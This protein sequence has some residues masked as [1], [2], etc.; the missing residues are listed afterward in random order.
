MTAYAAGEHV[1]TAS[2]MA[3]AVRAILAGLGL[4]ALLACGCSSGQLETDYGR[5]RQ[6]GESGSING[7]DVLADMFSE[8]GHKI[9]YRSR[10]ITA[11]MEAADTIVWFPNDPEP[12]PEEVCLWFDDWLAGRP[13][14]T[15]IYVGRQFSATSS[16]WDFWAEEEEKTNK[17]KADKDEQQRD[18][19][20]GRPPAAEKKT[21]RSLAGAFADGSDASGAD[22]EQSCE[23]FRYESAPLRRVAELA[24]PWARGV[25]AAKADVWLGKWM[26]ADGDLQQLLTSGKRP[27]VTRLTW[28][29]WDGSQLLLVANGSFLLNM[30]LVNHE[31]RELAGR[32][33]D[34]AGESGRVV[35]LE[36]RRGGPAIDPPYEDTSLWTLFRAWPLG[37]I[38]LQLAAVGVIFCFARWP[39]FGR[40]KQPPPELTADFSKHVA[41]V[42]RLLSRTRDR[43]LLSDLM[44]GEE[45][46]ALPDAPQPAEHGHSGSPG[47]TSSPSDTKGN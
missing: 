30:Q 46:R 44:S 12:P 40:P 16:Y 27:L 45:H 34:A 1:L 4:F 33:I 24:G 42:G 22:A 10:I 3:R 26:S 2:P 32:L 20:P 36:S 14:R 23:W 29:Y 15:L 9:Y 8:A 5:H 6:Q 13:D 17:K 43:T 21:P 19:K 37:A 25:D 7:T 38:L 18:K 39:I 35:F 47:P 28:P 41:A 31:N 11:E